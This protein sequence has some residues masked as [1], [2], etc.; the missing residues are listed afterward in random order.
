MKAVCKMPVEIYDEDL[1]GVYSPDQIIESPRAELL[2]DRYPQY[3]EAAPAKA[4]KG[5]K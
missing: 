1:R 5:G 4:Q 2:V 3:F